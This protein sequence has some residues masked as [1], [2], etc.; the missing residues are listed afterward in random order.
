MSPTYR[1]GAFFQQ[2]FSSHRLSL[3]L[4]KLALPE[5]VTLRCSACQLLH[6]LT[7][8]SV[9][10][11]ART[12]TPTAAAPAAHSAAELLAQCSTAHQAALGVR[13]MDVSQDFVGL[14]C[15]ECR[16]VYDLQVA[17]FETH[18]P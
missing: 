15:A 8:R 10:T 16:R 2:C 6:R 12:E 4:R 7:V 18:Q 1:S 11:K 13:D 14:R 9:A 3:S 5:R 17:E